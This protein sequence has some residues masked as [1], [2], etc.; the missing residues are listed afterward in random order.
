MYTSNIIETK[1]FLENE[2]RL[3][4][5]NYD[6]SKNIDFEKPWELISSKDSFDFCI[7]RLYN[8]YN[9]E[10]INIIPIATLNAR[11]EVVSFFDDKY[12]VLEYDTDPSCNPK[13]PK[14]DYSESR[15]YNSVDKIW[16]RILSDIEMCS[17]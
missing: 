2:L 8:G 14:Y 13:I 10:N 4:I 3:K 17:K 1:L 12:I 9:I 7:E 11:R 6:Y 15:V 5:L 16:K